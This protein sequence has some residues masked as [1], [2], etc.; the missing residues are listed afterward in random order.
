MSLVR[1]CLMLDLEGRARLLFVT[2]RIVTR[3]SPKFELP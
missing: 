3:E 2:Q 1:R